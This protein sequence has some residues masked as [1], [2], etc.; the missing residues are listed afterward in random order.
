[1]CVGVYMHV[2]GFAVWL[3]EAIRN[4]RL[5]GEAWLF[6][7]I[8]WVWVPAF[9][10]VS[11]RH[12]KVSPGLIC[13]ISPFSETCTSLPFS[14]SVFVRKFISVFSMASRFSCRRMKIKEMSHDENCYLIITRK[15]VSSSFISSV[16]LFAL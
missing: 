11:A 3:M 5:G 6:L 16:W 9:L 2:F 4:R 1:M 15:L 10:F 13:V 12:I 14:C 7:L 8:T